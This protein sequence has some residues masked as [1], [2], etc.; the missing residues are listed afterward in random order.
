MSVCSKIILSAVAEIICMISLCIAIYR[1]SCFWEFMVAFAN[2]YMS[3]MF[4]AM[5]ILFSLYIKDPQNRNLYPLDHLFTNTNENNFDDDDDEE[6][7]DEE[8]DEE[9]PEDEDEGEEKN[10]NEEYDVLAVE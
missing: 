2:A 7:D 5:L 1:L 9:E 8:E 6:E 10:E 3:L 4:Y